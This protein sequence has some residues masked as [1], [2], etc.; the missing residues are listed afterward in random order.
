MTKI[1]VLVMEDSLTVRKY[2]IEVLQSVDQFE[3][4]GEAAD[5]REGIELCQRLRPDVVTAD[6]VMPVMS[7]L[8]AT[9]YIMAYCPTPILIVSSSYNRGD[10]FKTLDALAA[11]AVDVLDK[12]SGDSADSAWER[13]FL[14]AVRIVSRVRVITHPAAKLKLTAKRPRLPLPDTDSFTLPAVRANGHELLAIGA[15]TGGPAALMHLLPALPLEFPLPILLVIH[16]DRRFDGAFAEWLQAFTSLP[17]RL[18]RDGMA[19]PRPGD[20]QLLLAPAD[21]HLSL[22]DGA[23]RL[24]DEGERHYCRPS[25]DVLFESLARELGSKT[26]ACLLSGMGVDGAAGLL[27]LRRA[28]AVTLA[29]DEASCVVFG[30]PKAAVALGAAQHVLPLS[31]MAATVGELVGSTGA[32]R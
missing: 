13:R 23:L 27:A 6:I 26:I 25:V 1:R 18:V 32:P 28:G 24:T 15:S 22:R 29:Q 19:L 4:V 8:A 11:G 21:R 31:E 7:G 5:G 9:E 2:L 16:L 10:I 20:A 14:Q 17:V 30:M 12:P 3:V